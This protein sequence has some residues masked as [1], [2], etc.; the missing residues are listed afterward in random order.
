MNTTGV[1]PI[2]PPIQQR[3]RSLRLIELRYYGLAVISVLIAVSAALF[4]ESLHFRDVAVPLPLFAVAIT[5][6]Y[7]RAGPA[8]LAVVL[9]TASFYW[10]FIEP[11]RTPY[12]YPSQI[13][14]FIVFVAFALL[15]SWFANA[16][17]RAEE[18]IRDKADLLNLTHDA[19]FVMDMKAV[20]KYWNRGSEERY[21]WSS[22]EA[23]GKNVHD[24]LKTTFPRPLDEIEAE[25]IRTG[26]WNAELVHTRKD[27]TQ[28]VVATR[29]AL[30]CDGKGKPVAILET[31]NDITERKRDEEAMRRSEAYLR[32]AQQLSQTGSWALDIATDSYVYASE[33]NYRIFGFDPQDGLPTREAIFQ[34]IH[35]DDRNTWQANFEKSLREK[36]DGSDEYRI[37]LPDGTVKH[38]Y[39][40]RH[41]VLNAA[42]HLVKWVGTSVDITERKRTE[43]ALRRSEAYLT[44]AQRLTHTGAWATDGTP[45]PL[46]WSEELFRL[47]GLDPKDGVPNHEQAMQRV[48]PED[49]DKYAQAFR[50][51]IEQKVDSDVEFRTVLPDGTIKYLYG[52]GHAVLNANGELVEAVGTTVDITERKR[53]EESLNRTTAYLVEAQRLTHTGAWAGDPITTAPLYWSEEV[54][55]LFGFDP[56]QGLPTWDQPLQRIHPE[57]REK[58]W[59]ALQKVIHEKVTS[60]CEYRILLPDGTVKHTYGTAHPFLDANGTIV[61]LVGSTVDITERKRAEEAIRQREKQFRDVFEGIPAMAAAIRMDGTVEF[62]NQRWRE[63]TGMSVEEAT[64]SGWE[65]AIHPQ[66]IGAYLEARSSSIASGKAYEAEFRLRAANGTYRWFLSRGVPL[67]D[68]RGNIVRWYA[69]LADIDDRKQTEEKLQQEN[70]ALREEIDKSSMF[71]EIVGSSAALRAVLSRV[72][73]VAPSDSTVLITGETGTGKEL[74]ARAIYKRSRR[75]SN[76]FVS[77]NCASIPRDLIASELFGHEKGAFTGATQRRLGRFEL[78]DRGT[79]F[80]DEVGDLP[81]ETQV[82]LLRVLQEREF[83]RVGGDRP[84]PTNVRVIAATNR[85]LQTA[86]ESGAFRSDL[87]YRLNV[88]PI[89]TP[90]LRKRREDIP[91]LV[92]YFLDRYSRK[93]GKTIRQIDKKSLE[94]LQSYPWPGN[95]RELQ[96]VIERSVIVCESETFSVDES[97]LSSQSSDEALGSTLGLSQMLA[98]EEK[99]VIEAALRECGGRV[100]GSSGAAAKL[101]VARS[102]LESK[103]RSF[104]IDK[105][106]FKSN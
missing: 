83:Q 35:P 40:V 27:G 74:I 72:T 37:V 42:G 64:G 43:E 80:L 29:W 24:L 102:T 87:F 70:V 105:N 32:E 92:A 86:I 33:E 99:Q 18:S 15:I 100:S 89:E 104:G 79:I 28:V 63:Y 14:Y 10:Y 4:L 73:K 3:S 101:G 45:K 61:E 90:P 78:A 17:R 93:S 97:W 13:P 88:F 96:N 54:F 22:E 94:L 106:R 77:V 91:V 57:D 50:K 51:V 38:I 5:S 7:G 23:V 9:S 21:G 46:Y 12:I 20:I 56:Q 76:A 58:F 41:A 55:R 36:V 8:T 84:I 85:N 47:Y 16:R 81:A 52:L 1:R 44:E 69:M 67:R 6:W 2:E 26:R 19:F 98:N 62:T 65:A 31:N 39:T 30:Q 49:R 34:R 95:I 59:Q 103:I 11:V 60:D 75:S 68:D 48:H 71:E 82:T 53:A 66:D 25:L